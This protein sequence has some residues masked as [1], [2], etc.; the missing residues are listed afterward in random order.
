SSRARTVILSGS[1]QWVTLLH[2]NWEWGKLMQG[3]RFVNRPPWRRNA[4]MAKVTSTLPKIHDRIIGTLIER[5]D[6]V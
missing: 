5:H 3:A 1:S 2:F 6:Y 4:A